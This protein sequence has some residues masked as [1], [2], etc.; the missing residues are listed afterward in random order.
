MGQ[1]VPLSFFKLSKDWHDEHTFW[2]SSQSYFTVDEKKT[3]EKFKMAEN[4]L[5]RNSWVLEATL[6]LT[7]R[8][9][10]LPSFMVVCQ[11]EWW[12]WALECLLQHHIIAINFHPL[13]YCLDIFIIS[14]DR[15]DFYAF[16]ISSQNQMLGSW[17]DL[18][19][20]KIQYGRTYGSFRLIRWCAKS[21][22]TW[23]WTI[24]IKGGADF[25]YMTVIHSFDD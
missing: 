21:R 10:Y 8:S 12:S 19:I 2:V 15:N 6:F 22:K 1:F 3:H 17:D 24:P 18:K 5:C 11:T 23:S 4:P 13:T 7:M 14:K 20:W 16:C 25:L 9:T